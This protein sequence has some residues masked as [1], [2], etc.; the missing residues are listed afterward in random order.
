MDASDQNNRFYGS[1]RMADTNM[2][3]AQTKMHQALSCLRE[4]SRTPSSR[5]GAGPS[6]SRYRKAIDVDCRC[7]LPH[8]PRK[9]HSLPNVGIDFST[10]SISAAYLRR[11][12]PSVEL[13]LAPLSIRDRVKPSRGLPGLPSINIR[14]GVAR[15]ADA[16]RPS[17]MEILRLVSEDPPNVQRAIIGHLGLMMEFQPC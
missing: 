17:S 4:E 11:I 6:C 12:E 10:L 13:L 14:W 16:M 5:R 2:V 3:F 9:P 7:K 15:P 8:S 1:A